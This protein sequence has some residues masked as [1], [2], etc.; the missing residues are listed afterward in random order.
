MK[1]YIL[2]HADPD[3]DNDCI[4]EK[5]VREAEELARRA[6]SFGL[7]HLYTSPF[8]RTRQTAQHIADSCGIEPAVLEWTHELNELISDTEYGR[9]A[10]WD[11][12]PEHYLSPERVNTRSSV[13][14]ADDMPARSESLAAL[15]RIGAESDAFFFR[16][17]YAR[18][19]ARYTVEHHSDAQIAV[20]C[21]LG[22]G[23]TWLSHLLRIPL[24]TVWS[25]FWFPP[26]SVSAVLFEE[27]SGNFAVPRLVSFADIS[28]LYGK[29]L[30]SNTRGLRGNLR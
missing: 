11:V 21:H 16:F 10:S 23:M 1:L 17:G 3:Y 18:D 6:A 12:P 25:G 26:A 4:T 14:I 19:G 20:V 2:R 7:T 30:D 28:H 8:R 15:E 22:F 24:D 5:G 27:R 9:L 29:G 13:H